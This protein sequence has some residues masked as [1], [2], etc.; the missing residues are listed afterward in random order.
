MAT[1]MA[2]PIPV[3]GGSHRI[4]VLDGNLGFPHEDP[5]WA[6]FFAAHSCA[7][8]AT[9]NIAALTGDLR[10]HHPHFA[11]VPAASCFF[12][13]DDPGYRGLAGA[14]FGRAA[15]SSL[16]SV[17]VVRRD[18]P[19]AQWQDLNGARLGYINTNCTTSY[20]APALLLA[21]EGLALAA[22][23]DLVAVAPWQGQ[24]DAVVAG[25]VDATMVLEDVWLERPEN[26]EQ[27]RILARRDGL[28]TPVFLVRADVDAGFAAELKAALLAFAPPAGHHPLCA[29]FTDYRED[30][31]QRFFADLATAEGITDSAP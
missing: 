19:R 27:T 16:S 6:A 15:S 4:G 20:L 14:L 17:L 21:S 3:G 26:A 18:S 8:S 30:L 7:V 2:E 11:F 25:A 23:F 31:M 22:F 10:K 5:A 13:R 12:L 9:T 1:A 29:G 24:I 28:P